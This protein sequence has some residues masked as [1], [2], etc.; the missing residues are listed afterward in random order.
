MTR[1]QAEWRGKARPDP[2]PWAISFCPGETITAMSVI[3]DQTVDVFVQVGIDELQF[4]RAV[5]VEQRTS[6]CSE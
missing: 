6:W 2:L 1:A 4:R 3:L 5:L